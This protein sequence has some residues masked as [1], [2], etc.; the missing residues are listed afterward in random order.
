LNQQARKQ[1]RIGI[2]SIIASLLAVCVWWIYVVPATAQF[3]AYKHKTQIRAKL[4]NIEPPRGARILSMETTNLSTQT[5][6]LMAIGTYSALSECSTVIAYYKDE[7]PKHGFIFRE[8][9]TETEKN[10]TS[11]T[12]S[13]PELTAVLTCN[14]RDL[15]QSYFIAMWENA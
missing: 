10:A 8:Q 1:Q 11:L 7:F 3:K 5:N 13:T 14:G 2:L 12:F 4:Y 15:P 6:Q 9:K